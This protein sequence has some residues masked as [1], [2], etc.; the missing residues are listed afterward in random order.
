MEK[1]VRLFVDA[2]SADVRRALADVFVRADMRAIAT[3]ELLRVLRE[4]RP[5]GDERGDIIDILIRRLE[6]FVSVA[7]A[8]PRM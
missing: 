5:Q 3:P 4:C 7:D 8:Q 1:L 2:E 6:R